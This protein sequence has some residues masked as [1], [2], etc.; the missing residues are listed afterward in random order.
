M[1]TQTIF[2]QTLY[3]LLIT[4][5]SILALAPAHAADVPQVAINGTVQ[6]PLA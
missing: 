3:T 4:G 5:L 1:K 6:I 2:Q